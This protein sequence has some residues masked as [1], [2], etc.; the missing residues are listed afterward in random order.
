MLKD[1]TTVDGN[2]LVKVPKNLTRSRYSSRKNPVKPVQITDDTIIDL[3]AGSNEVD[4]TTQAPSITV[5]NEIVLSSE[6]DDELTTTITTTTTIPTTVE[7]PSPLECGIKIGE[8]HP[9]IV[10]LEHTDPSERITKKTLSKGVLIDATHVL[11]TVSSI[12]N[13]HPFWNV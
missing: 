13:S 1:I 11:T 12:H 9:W 7:A 4:F 10:V 5:S 3:P 2:E 6:I 8:N